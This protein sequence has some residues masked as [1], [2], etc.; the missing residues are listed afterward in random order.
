MTRLRRIA[1]VA[2]ALLLVVVMAWAS[3]AP[4]PLSTGD[5]MVRISL[6]ARPE[7]IE[8]CVTQTDEELAKLAPQM[9]QR[10]VCEGVTA[11]YRLELFRDGAPLITDVV[12][13]GGLRH[14]RQLYVFRE[15]PVP[16]GRSALL[17]RL[18]RIDTLPDERAGSDSAR[19]EAHDED[20]PSDDLMGDRAP[21]EREER[22]RRRQE[23]VPA[24]LRLEVDAS[25]RAGE[26]LLLTYDPESRELRAVRPPAR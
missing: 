2:A 24:E 25:L 3:H 18:T 13:G 12:R 23:A 7:R 22:R 21:R 11:R 17:L 14:D 26:V 10:V 20:E 19:G 6:G 16:A 8:R 4:L 9:R 5:A 1:G 15:V